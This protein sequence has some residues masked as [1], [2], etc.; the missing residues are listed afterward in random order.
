MVCNDIDDLLA[1]LGEGAAIAL[2]T[3]E[4]S[5]VAERKL[6]KSALQSSRVYDV[7]RFSI[8]AL[9]AGDGSYLEVE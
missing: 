9:E 3:E 2:L 7:C 1:K 4:A 5:C 8:L 6:W